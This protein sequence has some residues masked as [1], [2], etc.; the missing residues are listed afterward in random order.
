MN[1]VV[2]N[3]QGW[4]GTPYV[5]QGRQRGAGCDCLGLVIGVW[6]DLIGPA[7]FGHGAYARDWAEID[8]GNPL[9]HGLGQFLLPK[10]TGEVRAGDVILFSLKRGGPAQHVG[11]QGAVGTDASFIHS[12]SGH[13][14]VE[15]AL[16]AAWRR[17]IVARFE[18]PQ[19]DA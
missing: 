14:V 16:T 6:S 9:F 18:F 11:I 10:N 4:I 12:Y 1:A 19:G 3:A 17:R 2:Q 5:H 13:G 15:S 8:K 7:E